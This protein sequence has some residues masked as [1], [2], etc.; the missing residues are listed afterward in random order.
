MV[1]CH[2]VVGDTDPV[3]R[4]GAVELLQCLPTL[5][6]ALTVGSVSFCALQYILP[7]QF[8]LCLNVIVAVIYK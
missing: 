6:S 1:I 7:I 8:V 3:L 2:R 4:L 5:T